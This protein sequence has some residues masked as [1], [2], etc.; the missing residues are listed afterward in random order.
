M[1]FAK[2]DLAVFWITVGK[3]GRPF[4]SFKTPLKTLLLTQIYFWFS[5]HNENCLKAI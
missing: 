1:V 5:P 2:R 4:R 3:F